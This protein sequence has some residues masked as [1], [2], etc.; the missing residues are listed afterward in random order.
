MPEKI[1]AVHCG[2]KF[3]A[4]GLIIR[5]LVADIMME[6]ERSEKQKIKEQKENLKNTEK[7]LGKI[8]EDIFK[9]V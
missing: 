8:M 1:A 5:N 7:K 6:D 4:I 2:V 9:K 3:A